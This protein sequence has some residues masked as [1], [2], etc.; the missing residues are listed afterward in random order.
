[1]LPPEPQCSGT[2]SFSAAIDQQPG[3]S[4]SLLADDLC[5]RS[6]FLPERVDRPPIVTRV[7]PPKPKGRAVS[8]PELSKLA[9]QLAFDDFAP[10]ASK[11]VPQ[12]L[13]P[14]SA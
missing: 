8:P 10:Y 3:P 7:L 11:S 14:S 6:T 1:M 9:D 5:S 13:K 2:Q 4:A 12:R